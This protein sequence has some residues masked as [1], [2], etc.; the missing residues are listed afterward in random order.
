M[1]VPSSAW[2]PP[3]P[4]PP[5]PFGQAMLRLVSEPATVTGVRALSARLRLV[6][7]RAGA[8]RTHVDVP[9]DKLQV[10]VEGLAFRTFTA[11]RLSGGDALEFVSYLHG[12]AT[13]GAKW[14]AAVRAGD[15]CHVRGPRRSL[16]VGAIA[17][18]T[19]F[20]GDETGIGLAAALCST[21]LG[22]LDTHF[23]LEVDDPADTRRGLEALAALGP[24]RLRQA[25]LVKRQVGDAHLAEVEE[26]LA[27][28][29]RADAY[30]HF[31]LC[32][33]A[34]AIQR[35]VRTLRRLGVAREHL[36]AK[37]YWA[38]GKVGLD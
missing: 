24:A 13:P 37:A 6:T 32:G 20:F 7:L 29:A 1:T 18:S 30:R 38:P 5:G 4:P 9:G 28:H 11:L 34:P 23:V 33:S 2:A 3:A 36:Q 10:R 16:D 26:A 21:P 8:F 17:R 14:L 15:A 25:Q 27:R 35:M 31:V 22:G 12:G 19:V